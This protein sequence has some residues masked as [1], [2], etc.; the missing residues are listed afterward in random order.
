[1]RSVSL[2][3]GYEAV[4]DDEDYDL[5]SQ[6]KWYANVSG[7]TVYAERKTRR[8]QMSMHRLI[9]DAPAHLCV[10]HIDGNGLNNTRANLRLATRQQNLFSSPS[11]ETASSEETGV[12]RAYLSGPM[13]GIAGFNYAAFNERAHALRKL[14]YI[15]LNPAENFGGATEHPDGRKAFMRRDIEHVLSVDAV[16]VLPGWQASKGATLEVAVARELDLPILDARTM[17]PESET[18]LEEAARLVGGHRG[19]AYGH[20]ADDFARTAAL[21]TAL[22]GD[23]LTA[24]LSADDVPA[25]M[26]MVKESRLR[27]SPRHRDSLTDIAGYALTQEMVWERD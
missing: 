9:L 24:P 5:V 20:P 11:R 15:V 22:L 6:F 13:T 26:R 27:Q 14:G 12:R 23:R 3:R 4:V 19:S 1:M 7:R 25:L 18:V 2:T 8:V 16:A 17:L 10:D 21:W